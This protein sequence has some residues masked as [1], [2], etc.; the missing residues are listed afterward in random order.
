[1]LTELPGVTGL[2]VLIA[3]APGLTRWWHGRTLEHLA[4]DPT[5]PERLLAAQRRSGA[6]FGA[7]FVLL[8]AVSTDALPWTLPLLAFSCVIAAYPLR[9]A[10]FGETWSLAGY[11]WLATDTDDGWIQSIAA[12]GNDALF[13]EAHYNVGFLQRHGLWR[14]AS[15]FQ[16]DPETRFRA[17]GTGAAVDVAVSRLDAQCFGTAL[18]NDELLCG[19]FDGTRTRFIA[20][21]PA[22]KRIAG[23]AWL[24]GRFVTMGSSPGEWQAGWR[25]G[26]PVALNPRRRQAIEVER[27][28]NDR[29]FQ[30]AAS[31]HLVGTIAYKGVAGSTVKLYTLDR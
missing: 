16:P 11:E 6:M 4:D 13:V 14:W 10:L 7:A 5:L 9:R 24:D 30:I 19:A 17:V 21:D 22:S 25:D 12:S 2:L 29:V 8:L 3:I 28:G 26:A 31:E 18:N 20:L 23:V 15:L 1:M 27:D